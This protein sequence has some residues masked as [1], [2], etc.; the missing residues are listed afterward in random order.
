MNEI[1]INNKNKYKIL[2]GIL[3]QYIGKEIKWDQCLIEKKYFIN[4]PN[5]ILEEYALEIYDFLKNEVPKFIYPDILPFDKKLINDIIIG[6]NKVYNGDNIFSNAIFYSAGTMFLKSIFHSYYKSSFKKSKSV[7]EKYENQEGLLNVIRYRL[8][9]NSLD[10][11][12]ELSMKVIT[13]GYSAIRGIVSFFK[14]SVALSIYQNLKINNKDNNYVLDSCIG[15]GARL[16][17][18][19]IYNPKGTYVGCEPNT[20]TYNEALILT[21]EIEKLYNH[22]INAILYN[23]TI[24]EF[25]DKYLYLHQDKIDLTFTSIP[26]Y[27][28][29]NYS[30]NIVKDNYNNINDWNDKFIGAL[31]KLPNCYINMPIELFDK[32]KIK[33]VENNKVY[34]LQNNTSSHL[35]KKNKTKQEYIIRLN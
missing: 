30:Q 16:L 19:F 27:D 15:F 1:L 10:E 22:P 35:N 4:Q 3:N 32:L 20:E 26:Y 23:C 21:K 13:K 2:D 7:P 9:I 34:Y 29:E 18:Y 6:S 31:Y 24:E 8:G 17:G 25:V 11:R 5:E 33:S 14:P 28:L 12:W